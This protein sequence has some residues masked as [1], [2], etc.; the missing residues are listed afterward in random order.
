MAVVIPLMLAKRAG[1][2]KWGWQV[3]GI[4]PVGKGKLH[5]SKKMLL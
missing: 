1:K 4:I 3:D 5:D 2:K